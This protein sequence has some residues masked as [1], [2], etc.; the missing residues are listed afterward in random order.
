M[1]TLFWKVLTFLK[2]M[3]SED[4]GNPSAARYFNFYAVMILVPCIAFV[5]IYV[6]LNYRDLITATLDAV[7]VFIM[8]IFGMKVWQKDKEN[9]TSN[10]PNNGEVNVKGET[11]EAAK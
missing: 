3:M 9:K 6:T 2:Q 5:L 7:L 10:P 4:N 8:G 1:K 11:D